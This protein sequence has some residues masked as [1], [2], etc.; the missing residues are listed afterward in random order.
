MS[1]PA[2]GIE[3]LRNRSERID[4]AAGGKQET[5]PEDDGNPVHDRQDGF[6]FD[7]TPSQPLDQLDWS[8]PQRRQ[9]T[10][11]AREL[12]KLVGSQNDGK[13]HAAEKTL[14]EWLNDGFHPV[15]FCR[16]L[17]T[18]R[19][20]GEQL[21]SSLAKKFPHLRVEVVTSEDPDDVR[22]QRIAELGKASLR[23]L[24]ATDCLSEGINLQEHFPVASR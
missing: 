18:A 2:A 3:M 14:T 8:D 13:L 1:S 16:Y 19:Y 15:V 4:D 21:R 10:T 7:F 9:L 24:V 6:A 20:V 11:F 22:R 12:E 17:A 23:L 5:E